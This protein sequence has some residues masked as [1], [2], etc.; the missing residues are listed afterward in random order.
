MPGTGRITCT[1][2]SFTD[3]VI[4]APPPCRALCRAQATLNQTN[5]KN[6]KTPLLLPPVARSIRH[7]PPPC[8]APAASPPPAGLSPTLSSVRRP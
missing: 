8:P 3:F 5:P 6:P 4:G 1:C 7:R 2:W